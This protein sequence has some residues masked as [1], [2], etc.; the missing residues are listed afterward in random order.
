MAIDFQKIISIAVFGIVSWGALQLYTL[1]ANM[2][3]VS[4]NVAENNTMIKPMW[5]DFLIR[6]A[7]YDDK[8]ISGSASNIQASNEKVSAQREKE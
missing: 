4:Y 3:V 5:K 6:S 1:N 2:A 8:R 7:G